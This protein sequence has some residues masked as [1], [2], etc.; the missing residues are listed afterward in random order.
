MVSLIWFDILKNET[1]ENP[2][3]T[4]NLQNPMELNALNYCLIPITKHKPF[5][6]IS[7]YLSLRNCG[8]KRLCLVS[9]FKSW[10]FVMAFTP[11]TS[12]WTL[13]SLKHTKIKEIILHWRKKCKQTVFRC[14]TALKIIEHHIILVGDLCVYPL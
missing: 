1:F 4:E 12:I 8:I 14:Q 3:L 7:I 10:F 6:F 9:L 5:E 2:G 13:I 11:L